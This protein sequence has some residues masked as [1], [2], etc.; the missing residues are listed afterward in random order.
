MNIKILPERPLVCQEIINTRPML[1]GRTEG[2]QCDEFI[3]C[4][5]LIYTKPPECVDKN[6][7]YIMRFS[8]LVLWKHESVGRVLSGHQQGKPSDVR[9]IIST[10]EG[11]FVFIIHPT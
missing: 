2:N 3:I 6:P 7:P 1:S 4:I 11:S 10:L 5:I 9:W 8:Q